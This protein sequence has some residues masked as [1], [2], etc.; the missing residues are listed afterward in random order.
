M[1]SRSSS[2]SRA[3]DER[4]RSSGAAIAARSDGRD[5][6]RVGYRGRRR[7]DRRSRAGPDMSRL[8]I[9]VL[10]G[11]TSA[12]HEVS[13]VSARSVLAAIDRDK[14]DVVPIAITKAGEW[15][16]P[17]R[18]PAELK[19]AEGS[20][21]EVGQGRAVV[22]REGGEVLASGRESIPGPVDLVFILLHGPG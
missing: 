16:L 5:G 22:L 11:G 15:L 6:T 21:P 2:G 9:A 12:E 7:S 4:E 14:Y 10:Y 17:D 19:A 20:L 3:R 1:R 18:A 8:R 13:V